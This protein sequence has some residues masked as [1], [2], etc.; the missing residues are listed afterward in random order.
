MNRLGMKDTLRAIG[1]HGRCCCTE[2]KDCRLLEQKRPAA[3][4][5][6]RLCDLFELPVKLAGEPKTNAFVKPLLRWCKNTLIQNEE[7]FHKNDYFVQNKKIK[8]RDTAVNPAIKRFRMGESS[9]SGVERQSY[10]WSVRGSGRSTEGIPS[11]AAAIAPQRTAASPRVAAAI[12]GIANS[13]RSSCCCTRL[14]SS[15]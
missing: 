5:T 15:G 9:F 8:C 2:K 7:I 14:S 4:H 1:M 11:R 6:G 13:L 10:R 3:S 12:L